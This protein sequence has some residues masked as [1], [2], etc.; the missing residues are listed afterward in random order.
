MYGDNVTFAQAGVVCVFSMV[1]VFLV[2]LS[3]SYMIDIIAKLLNRKKA[4]PQPSAQP[5]PQEAAP[6]VTAPQQP[7]STH[8]DVVLVTAAIAA[9]LGKSADQIVVRNIRKIGAEESAWKQAGK[10]DSLQ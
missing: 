4:A 1:V 6:Q 2:L 9:Y 8:A 7:A 3:I 5:A 10:L